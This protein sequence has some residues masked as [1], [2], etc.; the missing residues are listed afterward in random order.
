MSTI[1]NFKRVL[2]PAI[3]LSASLLAHSKDAAARTLYVN[4]RVGSDR[5]N[6]VAPEAVNRQTGP[7]ATIGRALKLAKRS[8]II[9]LAD[10]GVPYY[11]SISLVGTRHSGT[12]ERPFMIVGNGATLSGAIA[13]P[14]T[15]WQQVGKDLWKLKQ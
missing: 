13:V 10:T 11:E 14:E 9:S 4:N 2:L 5:F 3:L 8:D 7:V 15:A 1:L 12:G 6:G